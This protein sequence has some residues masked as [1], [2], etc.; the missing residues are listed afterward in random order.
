MPPNQTGVPVTEQKVPHCPPMAPSIEIR[1]VLASDGQ[2]WLFL[3]G[4]V[5]VPDDLYPFVHEHR[6]L[7]IGLRGDRRVPLYH[8]QSLM[9]AY[10][11]QTAKAGAQ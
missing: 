8:S 2:E 6:A 9:Q 11:S 4:G 10:K 7:L 3:R 1:I 5:G